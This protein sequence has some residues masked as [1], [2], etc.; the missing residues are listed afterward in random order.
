MAGPSHSP[1]KQ[2]P[3]GNVHVSER[4]RDAEGRKKEASARS[5]KHMYTFILI[6]NCLFAEVLNPKDAKDAAKKLLMT[7]VSN[8]HVSEE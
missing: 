5:Y 7:G 1:I 8:Y 3:K 6:V 2:T 4:V